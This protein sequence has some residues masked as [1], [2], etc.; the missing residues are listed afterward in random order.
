LEE[1]SIIINKD[2]T[3][4][5]KFILC[6]NNNEL[7]NLYYTV[8]NIDEIN[9]KKIK[10]IILEGIFIFLRDE[11]NHKCSVILKYLN[12]TKDTY[13]LLKL[14]EKALLMKKSKATN[15]F[16]DLIDIVQKIINVATKLIQN[17]H[18]GYQKFEKKIKGLENMKEFLIFLN[19]DLENW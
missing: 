8:S 17:G 3:L 1:L 19:N 16:I 9:T 5:N 14:R 7:Q 6:N 4:V 12:L 11:K 10:N 13:D 15:D 2:S 18:F